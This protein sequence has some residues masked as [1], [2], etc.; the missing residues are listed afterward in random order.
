VLSRVIEWVSVLARSAR[1]GHECS[2]EDRA[3]QGE[4]S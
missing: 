3:S 4:Q 2:G 1:S